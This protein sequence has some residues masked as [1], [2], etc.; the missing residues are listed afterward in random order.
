MEVGREVVSE[1]DPKVRLP[2]E[3]LPAIQTDFPLP[4]AIALSVAL[5]LVVQTISLALFLLRII[6]CGKV[7]GH[8]S[9]L[10]GQDKALI[11]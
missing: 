6:T 3:K 9:L 10:N 4:V 5:V 1:A 8:T 2:V 11:L 7:I